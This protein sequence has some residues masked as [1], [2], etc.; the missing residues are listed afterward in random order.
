MAGPSSYSLQFSCSVRQVLVKICE[1]ESH[2]VSSDVLLHLVIQRVMAN[3]KGFLASPSN[4]NL[5]VFS[6][7]KRIS[8]QRFDVG[9]DHDSGP[10]ASMLAS[11]I[12]QI[13]QKA[14]FLVRIGGIVL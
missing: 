11:S 4:R 3:G 9:G 7:N 1:E 14:R 10:T 6:R 5:S 8:P 13:L 2:T 12:I